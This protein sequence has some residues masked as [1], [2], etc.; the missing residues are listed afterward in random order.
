[1]SVRV[2]ALITLMLVGLLLPIAAPAQL[3]GLL[4]KKKASSEISTKPADLSE[5]D[6]A[7]MGKIEQMPEIQDRIQKEWDE[8]RRN[9]L[10]KVYGINRTEHWAFDSSPTEKA[11]LDI[12]RLY[13]NPMLQTYVNNIGQRLVPKDSPNLYS[14]RILYD[15]IP[16]AESLSTGTIYISTGLLSMLDNEAQ[17]A[18]VLGH[19]IAHVEQKHEYARIHDR[20]V[21]EEFIKEKTAKDEIKHEV[22]GGLAAV[23]GGVLGAKFGGV[24]GAVIGAA[25]GYAVTQLLMP[26]SHL[27]A[28]EWDTVEEDQADEYGAHYVLDAGYDVREVPRMYAMLDRTVAK[29]S[30]IGLG[31]MGN[32]RRVRERIGH[33]QKLLNGSFKDDLQARMKA[34]GLVTNGPDFPVLLSAA[35]RDNGI[36]ALDFDLY[37]M[38]RQNLEDAAAQRSTDPV[39]H[40]YLAKVVGQTARTPEEKQQA[41]AHIVD[42][43]RLDAARGSL[44]SLHLEYAI[45]LLAQNNPAN[46][47]QVLNELKTY[48][49]LYER[50]NGGLPANMHVVF[51]YFNMVGDS[52]WYLPAGWYRATQLANPSGATTIAPDSVVRKALA[53]SGSSPVG[54]DASADTSA[55]RLKPVAHHK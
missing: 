16:T 41:L 11:G 47:D 22:F 23:G 19:E 46:R 5:A 54:N 45:T 39:V 15:P 48:V 50:D 36:L 40:Y 52:A 3:G 29:D 28:T 35:K 25:G 34:Q 38:A 2:K 6:K 43:V 32:P 12:V 53:V 44:P 10:D 18:Y 33:L 26:H 55:P 42:A 24:P 20:V 13:N 17:L 51:D 30:R 27:V 7:L 49:A 8:Q 31:F 9:D 4:G 14:F 37:D 21:E 1:M